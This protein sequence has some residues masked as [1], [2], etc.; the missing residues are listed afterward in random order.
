MAK[1]KRRTARKVVLKKII[2]DNL[3]NNQPL[4]REKLMLQAGYSKAYVRTSGK[5]G[6]KKTFQEVLTEIFPDDEVA[7]VE[8]GQL[9]ATQIAHY[10]FPATMDDDLIRDVVESYPN[11]YVTHIVQSETWKRAYYSSPDNNAVGKSLDRIY[12]QKGHY[13]AEKL[14]LIDEFAELSDKELVAEIKMLQAKV[15]RKYKDSKKKPIIIS[16]D[17]KQ[18]P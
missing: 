14:Q 7:A 2:N 3:R 9:Y 13:A 15:Y 1:K 17:E 18:K 6:S 11:C 8:K 4:I 12:K 10:V 5:S 16:T